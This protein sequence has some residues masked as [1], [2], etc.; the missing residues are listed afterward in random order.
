M[1]VSLD[2]EV[3]DQIFNRLD[4]F[5]D[6]IET[7]QHDPYSTVLISLK[8]IKDVEDKKAFIK[9][10]IKILEN[11]YQKASDGKSYYSDKLETQISCL[12]VL[13]ASLD[14]S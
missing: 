5:I 7:A 9:K 4:L 10:A 14:I 13:E 12:R 2:S 3:I 11:T 6:R 8:K 1:K